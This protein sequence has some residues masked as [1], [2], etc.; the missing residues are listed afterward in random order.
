MRDSE[1][2][3]VREWARTVREE[4]D[5]YAAALGVA[6]P[7]AV[8]TVKPS[9]TISL[10]NGSSPGMHAP[11]APYY[12]RRSRIARYEPI[13]EALQEAGVPCEPCDYDSTGQTLVFAFPSKAP[14]G[15]DRPTVQSQSL[16]AQFE[17]QAFLQQ[18]WADNSVSATISFDPSSERAQLADLLREF[19]PRLKSTSCLPTAHGYT[20]APYEAIDAATYH[21]LAATVRHDH[22]LSTVAEDGLAVDECAGGAC[23]IR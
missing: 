11:W 3:R 12:L 16:R 15:A 17:R 6:R 20:Q 1:L 19:V 22:P 13:A 14:G 18:E 23:P 7:I 8:T 2:A 21:R 10:L 9:G 4:A 5:T